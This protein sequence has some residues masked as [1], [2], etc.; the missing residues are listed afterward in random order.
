LLD[1]AGTACLANAILLLD[2]V[3]EK[4]NHELRTLC[5]TLKNFEKLWKYL[6]RLLSSIPDDEFP[7]N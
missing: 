3:L 4:L 2:S 1:N 5:V 7:K 6:M